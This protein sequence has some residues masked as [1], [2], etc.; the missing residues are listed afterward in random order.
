MKVVQWMSS[1]FGVAFTLSPVRIP[2]G[3]QQDRYSCGICVMN[4]MEHVLFQVPL[5]TSNDRHRL[6]I[7]Y[8]V[9][10]ITYLRHREMGPEEMV[11]AVHPSQNRSPY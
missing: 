10:L 5:F 1:A 2:I 11:R 7:Q 8:F 9:N 4:A 3:H 6:R